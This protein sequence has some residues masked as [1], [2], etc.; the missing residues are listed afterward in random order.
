M[1]LAETHYLDGDFMK[2]YYSLCVEYR[3]KVTFVILTLQLLGVGLLHYRSSQAP[4]NIL[5]C[6]CEVKKNSS[7]AL[8][9]S[10]CL[11]D[12]S[13]ERPLHGESQSSMSFII[14]TR[15]CFGFWIRLTY[16]LAQD[17]IVNVKRL[18]HRRR[19]FY[20]RSVCFQKHVI[21][22]SLLSKVLSW[23]FQRYSGHNYNL[24]NQ[25]YDKDCH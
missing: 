11:I 22:V 19:T 21:H 20:L 9:R 3:L 17:L 14:S 25:L 18:S 16:T 2:T 10:F 8:W 1:T 12:C 7:S 5:P 4:V 24:N 13:F 15:K 23:F 6:C